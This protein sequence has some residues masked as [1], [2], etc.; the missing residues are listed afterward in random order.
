MIREISS[1]KKGTKGI[2][3]IESIEL[4]GPYIFT[5]RP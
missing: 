1:V 2:P 3:Q 5:P 4:V